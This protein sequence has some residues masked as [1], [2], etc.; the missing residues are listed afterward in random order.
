MNGRL[1]VYTAELAQ[2][3]LDALRNGRSLRAICRDDG[4]PSMN[5]V[6]KWVREDHDGFAARYREACATGHAPRGRPSRYTA[7]LGEW[8]LQQL[9][10]GRSLGEICG[11]PG[12]PSA[13]TV[14]LWAA[15]DTAFAA[16]YRLCRKAGGL[17]TG[18]PTLYS[19]ELAEIIF[20]ELAS[21][22]TLAEVCRDPGMPS[23][24]T[25]RGWVIENRGGFAAHYAIA[26]DLGDDVM[27]HQILDIVDNRR[28]DW[29]PVQKA[30]GE[31]GYVLDPQRVRRARLRANVRRMLLS[32]ALRRKHGARGDR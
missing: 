6:L 28:H 16:E 22:R 21:G 5:T 11:D 1:P 10:D 2:R 14:R 30:T 19:E 13:A 20:D 8:I 25:V 4:M 32:K 23:E 7:E 17:R 27:A 31:I 3:I 24:N 12:M 9:W 29:M 15:G 18:P 26:R